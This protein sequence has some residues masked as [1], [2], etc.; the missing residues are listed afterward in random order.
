MIK[1]GQECVC[2][3]IRLWTGDTL[4]A[5]HH[6]AHNIMVLPTVAAWL[7]KR[8]YLQPVKSLVLVDQE[9]TLVL[10]KNFED[11]QVQHARKCPAQSDL[12]QGWFRNPLQKTLN[13]IVCRLRYLGRLAARCSE[14]AHNDRQ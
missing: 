1:F 6:A 11:V 3:A 12:A 13:N 8:H 5:Q 2:L 7:H 14:P 4:V 9:R 10:E